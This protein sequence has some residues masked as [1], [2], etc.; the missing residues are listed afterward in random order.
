[1]F[2]KKQQKNLNSNEFEVLIKRLT[3]LEAR[4]NALEIE[5]ETL[6]SKV[7]RKIQIK[8]TEIQEKEA[9]T[10]N[11]NFPKSKNINILSPFG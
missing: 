9:E 7:L 8:S 6:R 10:L 2:W 4:F 11:S 5:N 3:T 1:M